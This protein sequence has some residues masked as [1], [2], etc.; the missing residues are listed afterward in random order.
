MYPLHPTWASS[1]FPFYAWPAPP[2][3][4]QH[5]PH[6]PHQ[7]H[8]SQSIPVSRAVDPPRRRPPRRRSPTP[9]PVKNPAPSPPAPSKDDVALAADKA[10]AADDN[11]VS[12]SLLLTSW[13]NTLA[14]ASDAPSAFAFTQAFHASNALVSIA[15]SDALL[16]GNHPPLLAQQTN[17]FDL[18]LYAGK[19]IGDP[20]SSTARTCYASDPSFPQRPQLAQLLTLLSDLRLATDALT[21]V[22]P[23]QTPAVTDQTPLPSGPLP[24][25][26]LAKSAS[27]VRHGI[28]LTHVQL[29]QVL[30]ITHYATD[31][32]R[33]LSHSAL[34]SPLRNRLSRV[35]STDISARTSQLQWQTLLGPFSSRVFTSIQHESHA[36]LNRFHA[37][38]QRI[39]SCLDEITLFDTNS[40]STSAKAQQMLNAASAAAGL[41]TAQQRAF[42]WALHAA[43]LL[44]AVRTS[45]RSLISFAADMSPPD[46][47]VQQFERAVDDA[48]LQIEKVVVY[49]SDSLAKRVLCSLE[50]NA[51]AGKR[52]LRFEEPP[53]QQ[54]S[55]NGRRKPRHA[56]MKSSPDALLHLNAH[57]DDSDDNGADIQS[58]KQPE[59]PTA[60]TKSLDCD[61]S[62]V[63]ND[64]AKVY[65]GRTLQH[66][67]ESDEARTASASAGVSKE[68]ENVVNNSPVREREGET[69]Q[70]ECNEDD[71]G[72]I[73]IHDCED[74]KP[75]KVTTH[76]SHLRS[77][78]VD[79]IP[80]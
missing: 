61:D 45:M 47:L 35:F 49:A 32:D 50:K 29:Q 55:P 48:F 46:S 13:T 11:F 5:Q 2:P 56:R 20:L 22:T 72:E 63:S 8:H 39:H 69:A 26:A 18:V 1:P 28:A 44:R 41:L 52:S 73:V 70:H 23:A 42:D 66:G 36:F 75:K 57:F 21:S 53:K 24:A 76:P 34:F 68:A 59:T 71:D 37:L 16:S 3:P 60:N 78:S 10:L 74:D 30:V 79:G 12:L 17:L 67:E 80:F 64:T 19:S 15:L 7:P 62:D 14:H 58:P 6:Q 51:T 31:I 9:P 25:Q 27:H 77:M 38:Q 54:R 65:E 33:L 43:V 40:K 4:Q